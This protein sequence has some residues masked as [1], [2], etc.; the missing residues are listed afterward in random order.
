MKD[1]PLKKG[2]HRLCLALFT[3][4]LCVTG[5]EITLRLMPEKPSKVYTYLADRSHEYMSHPYSETYAWKDYGEQEDF[6][7]VIIGD[8][9]AMGVGVQPDDRLGERLERM[10]NVNSANQPEPFN[11]YTFGASGTS[12]HQQRGLVEDSVKRGA[13][14]VILSI[15]L[16]DTEDWTTT[17]ITFNRLMETSPRKPTGA[18]A[19]WAGHSA[20]GKL[21][22]NKIAAKRSQNALPDYYREI[23]DKDYKGWERFYVSIRQIEEKCRQYEVPLVVMVWPLLS[24]PLDEAHYPFT[25]CH[26]QIRTEI[27]Q[28]SSIHF[29][30]LYDTFK[31][32]DPLRLQAV[33]ILDPHPNEIAHRASTERLKNFLMEEKLLVG[34]YIEDKE[35]Y[36][37]KQHI[38]WKKMFGDFAEGD[39][40]E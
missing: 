38:Y 20:L 28:Y 16:N 25:F 33:P 37:N 10:L 21:V 36:T 9:F 30:D 2:V 6:R 8:S 26:T 18:A 29:L 34:K 1:G 12:T 7:I 19:W 32:M 3:T 24:H 5:F 4:L 40:K 22:T 23:Y 17:D 15:C 35:E 13:D 27:E 31:D 11:V 39:T 14:L